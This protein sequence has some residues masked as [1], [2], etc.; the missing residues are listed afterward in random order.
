MFLDLRR[1]SSNLLAGLLA[2]AAPLASAQTW[3]TSSTEASAWV[4][5]NQPTTAA[6]APASTVSFNSAGGFNKV[7]R[8][9]KG[10]YRVEFQQLADRGGNVQAMAYG[11]GSERCSVSGWWNSGTTLL[12]EV[13]CRTAAG[14]TTDTPF[15]AFYSRE[16]TAV[17]GA[18]Y[19]AYLWADNPWSATSTPS[20]EYQ[21]NSS[22]TLASMTRYSAGS[23]D[24]TLP[25]QSVAGGSVQVTAY[26]GGSEHCKVGWWWLNGSDTVIRVHCFSASGTPADSRFTLN[27]HRFA[28]KLH[29]VGGY[30]WAN[31]PTS[32]N[33]VPSTGFQRNFNA[34]YPYGTPVQNTAGRD[35]LGAYSV[36]YPK[37]RATI[38]TALVTA[39]GSG[40]EYC[41]PENWFS[42]NGGT[43]VWV[44]CFNA[45]GTAVDTQFT[46]TYVNDEYFIPG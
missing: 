25:G 23:Y 20:P 33:Y 12:V 30:I 6:Y 38:G 1:N 45:S 41:K 14:D 8:V 5:A 13:W 18:T 44:R 24:V 43:R 27:Y 31:E 42:M 46:Q 21:W 7:F 9:A 34:E 10:Q 35:F 4:L 2:L 29:R 37:L 19:G 22:G 3:S 17:A 28:P 26:G 32:A 15:V 36:N 40:A 11:Y 16:T 39:Y